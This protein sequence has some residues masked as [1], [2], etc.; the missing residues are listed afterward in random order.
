M[1]F[2]K[3]VECPR[4]AMQG[5]KTWIPSKDKIEYIQSITFCW[6]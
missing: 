2:V 1:S 4:D 6:L 5:I 3:L